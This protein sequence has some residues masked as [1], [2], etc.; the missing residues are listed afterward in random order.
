[1][2]STLRNLA[3]L[4]FLATL[5]FG[6]KN[7]DKEAETK[8]NQEIMSVHDDIMPKMGNMNHLKM[9]LASYKDIVSDDNA[10]LKD[11]LIN[12]ILML[13]KMEDNMMDWMGNYKYPNPDATHEQNM[14]YLTG[15][16]D[17]VKQLSN[18]IYMALAVA[19]GL[20]QNKPDSL[21]K[22]DN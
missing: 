21:K 20:L 5:A 1:M 3:A 4:L 2:K 16:R 9:Q 19:N 18:D 8:I 7:D 6:C 13:S 22:K 17:S 15:Q 12:G 11:S 10:A 14:T